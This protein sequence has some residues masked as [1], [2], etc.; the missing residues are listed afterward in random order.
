MPKQKYCSGVEIRNY[1]ERVVE[2]VGLSSR[3]LFRTQ[4]DGLEWD[5]DK[6][7]WSVDVTMRR[8]HQGKQE[9]NLSFFADNVT[10]ASGLFP[11]PQVPKAPG[12]TQFDGAMFHTARWNYEVTGGSSNDPFPEMHKLKDK[13]VGIVG[14]GATA[15]QVI[16]QLAK[17][18]KKVYVFQRTPSHVFSRGQRDTDPEEWRQRI[19][20]RSG[21]QRDRMEN[22]AEVI[23]GHLSL[24]NDLVD[25][26]WTKLEG[27]RALVGSSQFGLIA[28]DKAQD[29][30]GA[31][32]ALDSKHA[33]KARSRISHIVKDEETARKLTPWYPVWCK[34]PTFSDT[35]L[36]TFN[37]DNVHLV[38]TDGAGIN[39]FSE[40]SV[41]AN[42]QEYPLDVLVLSTGYRSPIAG[43]DPGSRTGTEIIG[44]HGRRLADKWEEQ[45]MSTFHGILTNGYPNL[46]ILSAGQAAATANWTH[47]V[48]VMSRHIAS[49]V[50]VTHRRSSHDQ[51]AVL[52]EPSVEAEE[53]WGMTLAQGAAYFS[54][55]AVCT[56]GY[57]N[58]EGEALK[59][60]PAE[61]H[62]AMM[63]RAKSSIWYKGMVDFTRELETWRK[64]GKLE[65]LEVSVC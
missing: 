40:K 24:D 56:P 41:V 62:V 25:D 64:D 4:T 1:L 3:I 10:I 38:D 51:G 23:S 55:V 53:G 58:L 11:Y 50:D 44:R 28:P 30:I 20:A 31:M 49:I 12:L 33:E 45:G 9:M 61:D 5:D 47:V 13:V 22:F 63:K 37:H 52:I 19:A 14:T 60:P 65:G 32:L 36:E 59:M 46:F 29:H 39:D 42:G 26:E 48:E 16:P 7:A 6:K 34:R 2:Q 21:W 54:G 35:Y 15:I 57:L 27:Y 43:G 8:G 18:A 17:Y